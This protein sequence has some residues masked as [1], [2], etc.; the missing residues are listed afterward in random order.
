MSVL[1]LAEKEKT[2]NRKRIKRRDREE[3]EKK[4]RIISVTIVTRGKGR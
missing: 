2:T 3:M 1:R 4:T